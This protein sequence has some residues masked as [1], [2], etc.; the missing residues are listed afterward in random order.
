[1]DNFEESI[2]QAIRN[3]VIKEIKEKSFLNLHYSERKPLPDHILDKLWDSVD[4]DEVLEEIRPKVQTRICN[5]IVA[6]MET[7]LKTDIKSLLS[8]DGVRQKLRMEVYPKLM[9]VL[10]NAEV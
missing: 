7:E 10:N 1:M 6:S 9:S 3:S 5:M 2:A 8:V 4:W